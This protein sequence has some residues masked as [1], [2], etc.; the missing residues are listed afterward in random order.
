MKWNDC[1]WKWSEVTV[2]GNEII[3]LCMKIKPNDWT[4]CRKSLAV[5]KWNDCACKWNEMTVPENEM[6]RLCMKMKPND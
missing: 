3:C 5:A 2:P 6:I 4:I 1:A